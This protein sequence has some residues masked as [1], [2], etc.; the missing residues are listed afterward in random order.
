M[1]ISPVG[2]STPLPDFPQSLSDDFSP[3]EFHVYFQERRTYVFEDNDDVGNENDNDDGNDVSDDELTIG[4]LS[5]RI[6]TTTG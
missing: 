3:E 4:T 1:L 6:I 5:S 2:R